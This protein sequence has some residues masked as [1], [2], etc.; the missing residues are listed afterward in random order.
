MSEDKEIRTLDMRPEPGEMIKPAELID[1]VGL[2]SL[3]LTDRRIYNAL[4]A[5]AFG[6]QMAVRGQEFVIDLSELRGRHK[7][8]ERIS[9]TIERLMKTVVTVRLANGQTRRVQLLGGNDMDP[10]DGPGVLAYSFDPKLIAILKNSTIFG[11]LEI[12]VMMAF[13]SSYALALYEAI[14]RRFKLQG[15]ATEEF[16]IGQCRD[17]LGVPMGKL[18]TF[19]NLNEKAIKPAV[20]E[21]N[22]LATFDISV[23]PIKGGR[24]VTAVIIS[25]WAKTAD[26]MRAADRELRQ[27]KVG[28]KAR[29]EGT[30]ETIDIAVSLPRNSP[31]K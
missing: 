15:Q 30:V 11:K 29:I 16:T 14:A 19:G 17:L 27:P 24:K 12:A 2:S 28:R 9:D 31:N 21:I 5:N 13:T 22:A 4:I 18:A 7:G 8:Y 10:E 6:P 25:W 23:E 1:V 20:R 26:Q 3:T